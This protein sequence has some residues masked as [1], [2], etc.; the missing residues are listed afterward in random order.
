MKLFAWKDP[1]SPYPRRAPVHARDVRSLAV[2]AAAV[3][4]PSAYR[5]FDVERG[6]SRPLAVRRRSP[7]R[8]RSRPPR[9][10]PGRYLIA[11]T[12]EGMFGGRD[13]VC[14]QSRPPGAAVTPI[15]AGSP[16]DAPAVVD[17]LLPVAATLVAALFAVLLLSLLLAAAR[18]GEKAA[19]GSADSCCSRR[20]RP[21]R[22]S[23][24]GSGWSAGLFRCY[25]LFG[26]VLTVAYLGSGIGVAPSAAR[27][28]AMRW[29]AGCSSPRSRPHRRL[30]SRRCT[31]RDRG[32]ERRRPPRHSALGG[33]AFLWA[34]ALNSVGTLLLVGGALYSIARRQRVRANLWIAGGALVL[35]LAT[36]MTRA[37]E[38]SLVYLGE[39]IG[40]AAMF[41]GFVLPSIAARV[42]PPAPAPARRSALAR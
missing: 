8:L 24:R 37:G 14:L 32:D 1:Q 20:P 10:S 35:A 40:I 28:R 17:S 29:P 18:A 2:R 9:A 34:I 42:T 6:G 11:A 4:A 38:Y 16:V 30:R 19:L 7:S 27:G 22:R 31:R 26:G 33:H 36:S 21:A 12:H 41:Y 3:D 25:Y 13:F 39:L 15:G 23:A 5:L